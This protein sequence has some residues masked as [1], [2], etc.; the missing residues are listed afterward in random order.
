MHNTRLVEGIHRESEWRDDGDQ[1]TGRN[2]FSTFEE[3][4]EGTVGEQFQHQTASLI[5]TRG[6]IDQPNNVIIR[7]ERQGLHFSGHA[8]IICAMEMFEGDGRI[9]V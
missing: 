6:D 9:A 5:N 8:E 1:F 4:S 3:T 2:T 7:S